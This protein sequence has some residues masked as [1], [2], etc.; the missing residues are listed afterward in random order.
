MTDPFSSGGS[1]FLR[2]MLGDLL[3]MIRTEGPLQWDLA[4]Q[5]ATSVAAGD[6]PDPNPDPVL[7][8]RLEELS[9]IAQ[10]H[11]ADV[12]GM[13]LGIGGQSPVLVPTSRVEWA[14][15]SLE[16]WRPLLDRLAAALSAAPASGVPEAPDTPEGPPPMGAVPDASLPADPFLDPDT[17][18]EQDEAGLAEMIGQ[19]ATAIA[20]AMTAMQV[21]SVVGHLARRALGQYDLPLPRTQSHEILIVPD[22]LDRVA[23]EWSLP[24]EDLRLWLCAHEMAYHAVISRP[25]VAQRLSELVVAHAELVRPDPK[26]LGGLLQGI[27]TDAVPGLA[28]LMGDPSL[29]GDA[30]AADSAELERVRAELHALTAAIAGYAEHVTSV[31]AA[32]IIGVHAPIG[33]A[34]RRR[35]VGRGEG[36]R[37]AESLFGL[38]LDQE[39][40][41]RGAA[42][43]T[44]VLERSGDA[45]L[46]RLWVDEA[47][48][49]TPAE[50]DAPGLWLAR[51]NLP[52]DGSDGPDGAARP[53][54]EAGGD[55]ASGGPGA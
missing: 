8:I 39:E 31:V 18:D 30:E 38:R 19:W 12:T 55:G 52:E 42:F 11:V 41:D 46:A 44:G 25:H 9:A 20:P 14:R 27:D 35:R 50:V 45:D 37:V 49:P 21:G 16:S 15:R 32:R 2:K 23:E 5:L 53:D 29:F 33:E 43:V 24:P 48:L 4:F 51:I 1:D 17:Q 22:N 36:E 40:I 28:Q 34:M 3:R 13:V 7:R 47:N 6:E 54:A 10:L 26:D